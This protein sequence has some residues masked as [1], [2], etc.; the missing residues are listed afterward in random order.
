MKVKLSFLLNRMELVALTDDIGVFFDGAYRFWVVE[1]D[2]ESEWV[3]LM[4]IEFRKDIG[5]KEVDIHE[6]GQ[7][8]LVQYSRVI[9]RKTLDD[10][11][12]D[13]II[14]EHAPYKNLLIA[15]ASNRYFV[16]RY[17]NEGAWPYHPAQL[18]EV[19]DKK[20]SSIRELLRK[21]V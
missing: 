14:V 7:E 3:K 19:V 6:V 4:A 12:L 13:K 20:N 16:Y 21:Y 18:L 11:L 15:E 10:Y 2:D 1:H 5:V 9:G 8:L 17:S